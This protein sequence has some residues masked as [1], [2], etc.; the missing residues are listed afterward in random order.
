MEVG[1]IGALGQA[2]VAPVP[3]QGTGGSKLITPISP[4]L[5]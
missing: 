1:L 2:A 4:I 5:F 3:G